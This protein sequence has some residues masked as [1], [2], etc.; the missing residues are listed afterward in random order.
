MATGERT[1]DADLLQDCAH[2]IWAYKQSI[3]QEGLHDKTVVERLDDLLKRL[4]EVLDD[5]HRVA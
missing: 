4:Q 5:S 1:V 2:A 3:L